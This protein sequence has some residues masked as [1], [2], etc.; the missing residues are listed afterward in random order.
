MAGALV[1]PAVGGFFLVQ[2]GQR[3][4]RRKQETQLETDKPRA[5]KTRSGAK[6]RSTV[7]EATLYIHDSRS[8]RELW[9]TGRGRPRTREV[10][11]Y[12]CDLGRY[13]QPRRLC[14]VAPCKKTL[15]QSQVRCSALILPLES[16][17]QAFARRRPMTSTAAFPIC[18]TETARSWPKRR[19]RAVHSPAKE[20]PDLLE[21]A[22][23]PDIH[24][25][26]RPHSGNR[27]RCR[28]SV[29]R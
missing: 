4:R 19:M 13:I 18:C 14:G 12:K 5:R 24:Q 7:R 9:T 3:S 6:H 17:S 29:G 22:M 8:P 16:P 21:T 20:E 2:L 15:V 27:T 25:R 23:C 11:G 1:K 10:P 28:G 26:C